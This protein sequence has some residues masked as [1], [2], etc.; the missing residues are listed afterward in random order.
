MTAQMP[1]LI[2]IDGVDHSLFSEPLEAYYQ[3]DKRPNFIPQNTAN[4]RG[5]LASWEVRDGRLYL[6]KIV[7]QAC[8]VKEAMDCPLLRRSNVRLNDLFPDARKGPVFA[9]WFSGTLRVPTGALMRYRH[10][11][12][13]SLYEFDL[14]VVVEKGVVVSTS[15]RDNR[16]T[17]VPPS[18]SP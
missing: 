1:D 8:S 9:G 10:M 16:T 2:V 13:D 4:W 11:S 14:L 18:R 12:Y 5:Y 3:P 7:G 6:T 17:I 15:T